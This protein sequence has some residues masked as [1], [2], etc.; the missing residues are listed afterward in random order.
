MKDGSSLRKKMVYW[1]NYHNV[2]KTIA[3]VDFHF[4]DDPLQADDSAGVYASEHSCSVGVG[5]K[6]VNGILL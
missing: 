3:D 4:D 5:A 1:A 2:G 6:N